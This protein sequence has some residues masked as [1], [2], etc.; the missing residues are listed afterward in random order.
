MRRIYAVVRPD[1][2][3][4]DLRDVDRVMH[5]KPKTWREYQGDPKRHQKIIE[6]EM[7]ELERCKSEGDHHCYIEN[8]LHVAAAC[9]IAH[10]D[11][12]C[13]EYD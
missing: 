7:E 1:K 8:L 9:L 6:M 5:H 3:L 2:Y 12:T 4:R 13:K 10:H 11:M